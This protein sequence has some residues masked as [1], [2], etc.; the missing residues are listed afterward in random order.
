VREAPDPLAAARDFDLAGEPVQAAPLGNGHIH[1]TFLVTC[2]TGR[3]IN[4]YVL[5]RLNRTVFPDLDLVM[6]NVA[7]VLGHLH[8]TLGPERAAREAL[9]LV[10][11]R[12]GQPNA[13]DPAGE[14][15]RAYRFVAGASS[16]DVARTPRDAEEAARAFATFQR[17]LADLPTPP[18]AETIPGFHDTP[19]RLAALQHA[20]EADC[21]GRAAAA[22]VEIEFALENAGLA[23]ALAALQRRGLLVERVVHN[24][25][26][27]NNVLLDDVTGRAVCVIDLDTV[28][29]GLALHDFGDLVRSA[30]GAATEDEP[31][32]R[33]HVVVPERFAAI[34]RGFIG[35]LGGQLS[36]LERSN[37]ALAARV[38]TFECG[39]RFLADHLDGDRYF[40]ARRPG[41]NLDRC[42]T[43]FALLRSL[44]AREDELQDL[45]ESIAARRPEAPHAC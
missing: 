28:M 1:E 24:D 9:T 26:K 12:D 35:G 31:E 36:A 13:R 43:Q 4:R 29:P 27:L 15:W 34:A 23:D 8:A 17:L 16:H 3:T 18:L 7:R 10:P 42:R 2:G 21:A 37:L 32:Y 44:A 25:T 6:A 33:R 38:M 41:H 45:V 39:I 40:R 22:R 30:A 20:I 14:S 19:A 11:S 5:Q